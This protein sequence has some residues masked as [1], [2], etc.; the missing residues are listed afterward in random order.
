MFCRT[1]GKEVSNE[2]MMCIA[3]G[4]P[5][6]AG[7]LHCQNCGSETNSNAEMCTKCGVRLVGGS[8]IGGAKSKMAAGLLAIF[9]GGIG[10][11]R[12]YLGY[13]VIGICQL[14]LGL[15]GFV[16]CGITSVASWVWGVIEGVLIFTGSINKDASGRPL[17]E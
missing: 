8:A 6:T 9:L 11:H 5:P 15:L 7:N 17:K 3:C 4:S 10:I 2:A 14:I 12:F 1:C 16:T 13:N